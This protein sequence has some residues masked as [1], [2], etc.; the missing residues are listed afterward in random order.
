MC[1]RD[2]NI[3]AGVWYGIDEYSVSLGDG[4]YGG[5][6]ALPAWALFMK[7]AHKEL[8]IPKDRFEMPDGVIEIEIDSDTKQLPTSR[9]KNLEKE[10]FLRSNVPQ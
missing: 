1:I 6:A 5:V 9:T 8:N 7:N 2:R 3:T 10:F 4:Q